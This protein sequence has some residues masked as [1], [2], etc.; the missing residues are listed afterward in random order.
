M[1]LP[2]TFD[3]LSVS[4]FRE[5]FGEPE[6]IPGSRVDDK[7]LTPNVPA[8]AVVPLYLGKKAQEFALAGTRGLILSDFGEAFEP[9]TEQRLGMECNI[10]LAKKAPRGSL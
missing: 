4:D 8:H 3:G 7:P 6:V 9:A 5:K 1:K 2:S 10:P